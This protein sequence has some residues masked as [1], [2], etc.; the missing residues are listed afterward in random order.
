MIHLLLQL[1]TTVLVV[2][3]VVTLIYMAGRRG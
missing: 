3:A 2:S 1:G